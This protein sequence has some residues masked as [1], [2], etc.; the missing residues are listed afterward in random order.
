M[1]ETNQRLKA[2]KDA[3]CVNWAELAESIGVSRS[4]LDF[5]RSGARNPGPKTM[6]RIAAAE[7][8]AG[9]AIPKCRMRDTAE[10]EGFLAGMLNESMGIP[11][12]ECR[13]MANKILNTLRK[14]GWKPAG[15]ED[16]AQK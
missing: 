3:L 2:L 11:T 10:A 12:D 8:E 6:R 9:L 7:V 5:F 13:M 4:G 14:L 1:N 16:K 15:T